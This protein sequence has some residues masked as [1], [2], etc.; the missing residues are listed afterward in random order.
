MIQEGLSSLLSS[1]GLSPLSCERMVKRRAEALREPLL[2]PTSCLPYSFLE[3][4]AAA[5]DRN[6]KLPEGRGEFEGRKKRT[7]Y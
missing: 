5:W 2:S 4:S 3:N 7:N 6:G 1:L